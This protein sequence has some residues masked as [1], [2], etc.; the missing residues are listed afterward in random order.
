M[1]SFGD[2]I[3]SSRCKSIFSNGYKPNWKD[4][5]VLIKKVKNTSQQAYKIKDLNYVEITGTC[6]EQEQQKANQSELELKKC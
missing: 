4:K 1:I 3:Q 5:V 6:Y 2:D